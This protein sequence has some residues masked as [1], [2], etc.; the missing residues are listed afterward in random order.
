MEC[1][2]VHLS[3]FISEDLRG[4]MKSKRV[5]TALS[6]KNLRENVEVKSAP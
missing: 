5:R 1:S 4:Y 2:E 3:V 6:V